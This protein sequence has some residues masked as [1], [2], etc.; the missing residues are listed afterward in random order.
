VNK[1]EAARC[2]LAMHKDVE[3]VTPNYI[4]LKGA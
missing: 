3:R 1:S 2:I 4:I